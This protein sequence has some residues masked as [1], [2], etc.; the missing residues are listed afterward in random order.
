MAEQ[1]GERLH[2]LDAVRGF[3]LLLGVVF[4]ATVSFIPGP[5]IW[6]V[7]DDQRDQWFGLAFFCL[8]TFRMTTFF[9]IAGFFAH[10]TFH[11]RGA[12]GFIAD[13]LKRI[14]VPL[15]VGW[16]ILF[17]AIVVIAIWAAIQANGGKAPPPPPQTPYVFGAFPLTHLWFL[18]VLLL[19]YAA[20]LF[21]RGAVALI[22]RAGVLRRFA[23]RIVGAIVRGPVA[24]LVL[25]AP[26]CAALYFQ[27]N[28]FVMGGIP[29]PDSN[30]IP[31]APAFIGFGFA[32][33]F[34]ALLHRQTDL[35]RVW[36]GRWWINLALAI[37][38]M[39]GC[40]AMFA[41]VTLAAP[42]T[43]P[44]YKFAFAALYAL[45]SWT[46]TMAI[47]GI[48]LRFLARH[49]P[50]RRY[51]ADA[52]Y[53]IYLVHLPL[54]LALQTAFAKADLPAGV[55]YALILAIALPLLFASYQVLVRRTFIG[56][57]LNGRRAPKP[58][59]A[60]AAVLL[61]QEAS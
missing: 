4:H 8:H 48:A 38:C 27:P 52:S 26:V 16:P 53:W 40:V 24:P 2:A 44:P 37:A 59:A 12:R 34:G 23:D 57:I 28:W 58:G 19:F 50:A 18:Y 13:R 25:A 5:Q 39:A 11:K 51:V 54:V 21:A 17:G 45:T 32:F 49:S 30:L 36:R 55:K 6:P 22:D 42:E 35:L 41:V 20:M 1:T 43:R 9:L 46:W 33:A 31:N 14:G 15:V 47:I 7:M 56:A 61:A 60:P 29:T 3:A 10:M